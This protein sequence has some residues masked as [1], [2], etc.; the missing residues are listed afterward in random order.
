MAIRGIAHRTRA[1]PIASVARGR[2]RTSR[3]ADHAGDGRTGHAAA[4]GARKGQ[5]RRGPRGKWF[6]VS[7]LR[8]GGGGPCGP[9]FH[10]LPQG[11]RRPH[12]ASLPTTRGAEPS[13]RRP[14]DGLATVGELYQLLSAGATPTFSA[15]TRNPPT[16]RDPMRPDLTSVAVGASRTGP[17]SRSA[18]DR[19]AA[20]EV[21]RSCAAESLMNR[22]GARRHRPPDGLARRF[23][24]VRAVALPSATTQPARPTGPPIGAPRGEARGALWSNLDLDAAVW[25]IPAE[26]MKARRE[27]RVP[28]C[29]RR[30]VV[31]AWSVVASAGRVWF[32]GVRRRSLAGRPE[33]P[34]PRVRGR[35][36]AGQD[37]CCRPLRR[38]RPRWP[39]G[40]SFVLPLL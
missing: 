25:T 15:P 13:P 5:R 4:D 20:P 32:P 26:R 9:R 23:R 8:G 28:L 22:V 17:P 18:G 29:G 38:G 35:G 7:G 6:A 40:S 21:D 2:R 33:C 10:G 14:T 24:S 27:H 31:M 37:G 16:I 1:D 19:G 3:R 30:A 11:A 39:T 34:S 12:H 36:V